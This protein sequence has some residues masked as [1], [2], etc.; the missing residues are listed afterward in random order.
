M[1]TSLTYLYSYLLI[2]LCL[3]FAPIYWMVFLVGLSTIIDTCFGIWKSL[4]LKQK[5]SSKLC[6]K[7][8]VPKATSYI[9]LVLIAFTA[10]FHIVNEFT[11]LFVNIQFVSTKLL[12]MVLIVIEFRSMDESF[13]LVKGYSFIDKL[14][15][16]IK[17]IKQ[18]KAEVEK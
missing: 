18:V 12:A 3:F 9:A 15:S 7:G 14:M 4:K 10:D 16:N 17:K 2:P 11:K 6:R 13:K 8:L 5:V 1:K